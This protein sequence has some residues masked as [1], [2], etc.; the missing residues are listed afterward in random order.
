[1]KLWLIITYDNNTNSI[2][3]HLFYAEEISDACLFSVKM[4]GSTRVCLLALKQIPN[5]LSDRCLK[6][7]CKIEKER[8]KALLKTA[9]EKED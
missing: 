5:G 8:A 3:T 7:Y 9:I 4:C 2:L 6:N 1:M